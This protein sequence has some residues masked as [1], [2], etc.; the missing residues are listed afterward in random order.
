MQRIDIYFGTHI[1]QIYS[2]DSVQKKYSNISQFNAEPVLT[3]NSLSQRNRMRELVRCSWDNLGSLLLTQ[4]T[5]L[6]AEYRQKLVRAGKKHKEQQ[7]QQQEQQLLA[8]ATTTTTQPF[9]KLDTNLLY[10]MKV[11][12]LRFMAFHET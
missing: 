10:K 5:K 11:F 9:A 4:V 12:Y 6:P 8:K 1:K 2:F 3:S 7:Q